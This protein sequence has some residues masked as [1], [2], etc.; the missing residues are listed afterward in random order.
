MRSCR[1]GIDQKGPDLSAVS[2]S[3]NS[4]NGGKANVLYSP[5]DAYPVDNVS[6]ERYGDIFDPY[7]DD[8]RGPKGAN[9][10]SAEDC[11]W[12][13]PPSASL[14][15]CTNLTHLSFSIS[16]N[17]RSSVSLYATGIAFH[18]ILDSNF[19]RSLS[20]L[21][22]LTLI[23]ECKRESR[24]NTIPYSIEGYFA[25]FKKTR[26]II[27]LC[28]MCE[29]KLANGEELQT[30]T[31]LVEKFG[32]PNDLPRGVLRRQVWNWDA[33]RVEGN[34]YKKDAV[35]KAMP[36]RTHVHFD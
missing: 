31:G 16:T 13:Q 30:P 12:T 18:N 36:G 6:I 33:R 34:E 9:E 19:F 1:T 35:F 15:Q 29:G 25:R 22:H 3:H 14:K 32:Q 5:N 10:K 8:E 28:L 24:N 27:D 20:K 7:L 21:Q 23:I 17:P 26:R 2:C 4:K 11:Y